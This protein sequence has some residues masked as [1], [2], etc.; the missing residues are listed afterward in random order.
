MSYTEQIEN[1]I[2]DAKTEYIKDCRRKLRVSEIKSVQAGYINYLNAFKEKLNEVHQ[3]YNSQDLAFCLICCLHQKYA[4]SVANGI[5]TLKIVSDEQVKCFAV[6]SNNIE[7]P[8]NISKDDQKKY[9][10]LLITI[11][12]TV[13]RIDLS[14]DTERNRWKKRLEN[15]FDKNKHT[16][17]GKTDKPKKIP[18]QKQHIVDLCYALGFSSN[19]AVFILLRLNYDLSANSVEDCLTWFLL[20]VD[21][22]TPEDCK[23]ILEKYQGF[24][25]DGKMVERNL[26]AGQTYS[27]H[28]ELYDIILDEKMPL[29]QKVISF[30]KTLAAKSE[31]FQR[32]SASARRTLCY[33]IVTTLR[34]VG[35]TIG[36]I[37]ESL[38]KKQ[39][40]NLVNAL[41]LGRPDYRYYNIDLFAE[42]TRVAQR[43]D[44]LQLPDA[45][46]IKK[47]VTDRFLSILLG[48]I[49]AQKQD[50]IFAYFLNYLTRKK[51]PE[52][53]V[54]VYRNFKAE[55]D[56]ELY[57]L[58]LGE[59]YPAH[60][61]EFAIGYS[62][63]GIAE[64]KTIY[65]DVVSALDKVEESI[66]LSSVRNPAIA[67]SPD[68]K[69]F[70]TWLK[71]KLD[72]LPADMIAWMKH[73]RSD[74]TKKS[75]FPEKFKSA[76]EVYKS[77]AEI[78]KVIYEDWNCLNFGPMDIM[79]IEGEVPVVRC[80]PL[81]TGNEKE[82]FLPY[83]LMDMGTSLS[84]FMFGDSPLEEFC[85][86]F[87]GQMLDL[88]E[89]ADIYETKQQEIAYAKKRE[90]VGWNWRKDFG[91]NPF[92]RAHLR[93]IIV[94][95]VLK[96]FLLREYGYEDLKTSN[97]PIND[98]YTKDAKTNK[99]TEKR[100][101]RNAGISVFCKDSVLLKLGAMN[102]IDLEIIWQDQRLIENNDTKNVKGNSEIPKNGTETSKHDTEMPTGGAETPKNDAEA[103]KGGTE[104]SKDVTATPK[105]SIKSPKGDVEP[106]KVDSSINK[107]NADASDV[108]SNNGNKSNDADYSPERPEDYF[109]YFLNQVGN[110]RILNDE[111]EKTLGKQAK[112][113]NI[114][115]RNELI[116]YNYKLAISLAKKDVRKPSDFPELASAAIWGL[117]EATTRYDPERGTRFSTYAVPVIKEKIR[118]AI[119]ASKG[120]KIPQ[121]INSV[122]YHI[123][124]YQETFRQEFK[125]EPNDDEI[126]VAM[127]ISGKKKSH[128]V[129]AL[130][131]ERNLRTFSLDESIS[132]TDG[133]KS[134]HDAV[135][136]PQSIESRA[137]AA[138]VKKRMQDAIMKLP[139]REHMVYRMQHGLVKDENGKPIYFTQMQIS[140]ELNL[141]LEEVVRANI[142]A[143]RILQAAMDIS[144]R[145]R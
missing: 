110:H 99:N 60:A 79:F 97:I 83:D 8:G 104:T 52:K 130:R 61:L 145:R 7:R 117:V 109:E 6:S 26:P 53:P 14:N 103:L 112:A 101:E 54:D 49:S 13:D 11:I 139:L 28:S 82:R 140:K 29:E 21:G 50:I 27:T 102:K 113:G 41:S 36:S 134:K 93:K 62:L 55:V 126:V 84:E 32:V 122:L 70:E 20:D 42:E 141:S 125:A 33:L 144:E 75:V 72:E 76:A 69:A 137:E 73:S 88:L 74:A 19:E 108:D 77:L 25:K 22:A 142:E 2:L 81:I 87:E 23:R 44:A 86:P 90:Y 123:N 100:K 15:Y 12:K 63:M 16:E 65:V 64:A 30:A 31:V 128:V 3:L 67:L 95:Q 96:S 68:L 37:P 51:L 119:A 143:E 91:E 17:Y 107:D 48:R 106:Q 115:A 89:V 111:E 127:M 129:E 39:A 116:A 105:G 35:W 80:F 135:A 40:A 138:L 132:S 131:V 4:D 45:G 47:D 133:A 5:S 46:G 43:L 38:T 92:Y 66:R 57:Q 59:F 34:N 78:G 120:I 136:D 121:H 1:W 56:D 118:N 24:C 9:I 71:K 85:V 114:S 98:K 58:C 10:K 18:I 94:L 124:E